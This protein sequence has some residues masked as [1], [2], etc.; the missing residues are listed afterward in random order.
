MITVN[1]LGLREIPSNLEELS[2]LITTPFIDLDENS[3]NFVR[4]SLLQCGPMYLPFFRS[5]TITNAVFS[6]ELNEKLDKEKLIAALERGLAS[7]TKKLEKEQEQPILE[8]IR[9]IPTLKLNNS[10]S[11]IETLQIDARSELTL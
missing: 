5:P 3:Q 8:L 7:I 10:S 1:F 6:A 2:T 9:N 4:F 11:L